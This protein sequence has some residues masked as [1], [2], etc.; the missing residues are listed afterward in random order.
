MVLV[1]ICQVSLKIAHLRAITVVESVT[2]CQMLGTR[3]NARILTTR[4]LGV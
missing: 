4:R 2:N 1:D 3:E